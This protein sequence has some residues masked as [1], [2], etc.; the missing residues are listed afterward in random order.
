[1][2]ARMNSKNARRF[3]AIFLVL[4]MSMSS[5]GSYF[6]VNVKAETKKM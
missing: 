4:V 1:M 3:I 2:L 6:Q 5:F